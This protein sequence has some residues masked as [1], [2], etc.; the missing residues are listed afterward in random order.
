MFLRNAWYVAAW[1]REVGDSPLAVKVLG[2]QLAL[3]RRASGRYGALADACPHRK[4]PL[5]MGRVCGEAI[6]CGYHGLVFDESGACVRAPFD[7]L[8]PRGARVDAH[9]VEA[10]Y[11]LL[12][13]WMGDPVLADPARIFPAEHWGDPQWGSTDGDDMVFACNYLHI[14]DNLLDPSHVAWVHPGSFAG[15]G[16]DETPLEVTIGDSGVTVWRWMLD[17]APAPF[18]APFLRFDGN[19]D[20]KQQYEMRYPCHALIKAYISP[21][22][23]G[24]EGQ[25]LHPDA[26]VMDSFNF[27]TPVDERTTRYFWFQ[28]RNFAPN[29]DE[30][31]K[32]FAASVRAAFEEDR[33]ILEAS[34]RGMDSS[35]RPSINLRTD[36]GGIRFRHRLGQ[37]IEAE[38][39][40]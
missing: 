9:P 29:D 25:E 10:R 27:L 21:A 7:G 30:V 20:R 32:R 1:E 13:V 34:Q 15:D 28:M 18:Y 37:L 12:W 19:C 36:S 4:V 14:T 31:S 38:S 40:H 22:G 2:E 16:S 23:H 6:E 35:T 11:G 24:G 33:T 17:T 5:S 8:P 39:Q 26:F 3:Y